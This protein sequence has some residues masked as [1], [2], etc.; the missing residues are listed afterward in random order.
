VPSDLSVEDAHLLLPQFDF[1][2][3]LR[4]SGEK[5]VFEA[6]RQDGT[7]VAIKFLRPEA[8]VER[9]E[10]E[11]DAMK[12]V[13]CPYVAAFYDYHPEDTASGSVG[14]LVE[15]YIDGGDLKERLQQG[16]LYGADEF[17]VFAERILGGIQA[18]WEHRIVHRDIKPANIV[19]RS[20]SQEPVIIDFGIARH[21]DQT[22][23][24]PTSLGSGLCTPRYAAPE[25]LAYTRYTRKEISC[26]SDLF[27]FGVVSYEMLAGQ[28]PYC[29]LTST[30]P[31]DVLPLL[32]QT[33]IDPPSQLIPDIPE[34]LSA[35]VMRL[36][37][38]SSYLRP[39]DPAYARKLLAGVR[40]GMG[41]DNG[42]RQRT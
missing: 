38:K 34:P 36:L 40:R 33:Q 21:V 14:Y 22:S 37:E 15:E 41:G 2:R 18:I 16:K 26:R 20:G 13:R 4:V 8:K 10:R 19:I 27:S 11:V 24:T 39:R 3:R 32:E 12:K 28:H 7:H 23:L 1:L 35:W 6:K 5:Q 29:D 42:T 17:L 31:I 9:V 25:V 30:G